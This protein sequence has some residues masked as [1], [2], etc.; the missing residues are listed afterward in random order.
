MLMLHPALSFPVLSP[1][2]PADPRPFPAAS[3][4]CLGASPRLPLKVNQNRRPALRAMV[5]ILLGSSSAHSFR[6]RPMASISLWECFR[7]STQDRRPP[8]YSLLPLLLETLTRSSAGDP[9]NP[10]SL[11]PSLNAI[12]HRQEFLPLYTQVELGQPALRGLLECLIEFP[13]SGPKRPSIPSLRPVRTFSP[14]SHYAH[15]NCARSL[16]P[17]SFSL[18]WLLM[19]IIADDGI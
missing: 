19:P 7:S 5:K 3:G 10:I 6:D 4:R 8:L 15:P 14:V 17:T 11:P 16:Y 9:P 12:F 18:V 2:R 13:F 1:L